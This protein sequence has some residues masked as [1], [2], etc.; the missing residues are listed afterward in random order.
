ML[1]L[2]FRRGTPGQ[3]LPISD[4]KSSSTAF[5]AS[6]L[7]SSGW[8]GSDHR[9]TRRKLNLRR[10]PP[11]VDPATRSAAIRCPDP[12]QRGGSTAEADKADGP[13]I[14]L[15]SSNCFPPIPRDLKNAS[16][17]WW[18]F[19]MGVLVWS[20]PPRLKQERQLPKFIHP[21]SAV[22]V[23]EQ[24]STDPHSRRSTRGLGRCCCTFGDGELFCQAANHLRVAMF[25]ERTQTG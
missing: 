3:L 13:M 1:P 5:F 10:V 23:P 19:G 16:S 6:A 4:H 14:T 18:S 25:Q 8:A 20:P 24:G 9:S 11:G 21:R 22:P 7:R 17:Q 2:I 12:P 15:G